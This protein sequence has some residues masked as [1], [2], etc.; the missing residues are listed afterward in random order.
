MS[1]FYQPCVFENTFR[2]HSHLLILLYAARFGTL[3]RRYAR[4]WFNRITS[5]N[6]DW[7][8]HRAARLSWVHIVL[9]DADSARV[10]D[11]WERL[12]LIP[13][14]LS[15]EEQNQSVVGYRSFLLQWYADECDKWHL[16]PSLVTDPF[17]SSENSSY[18]AALLFAST[19]ELMSD[20]RLPT[21]SR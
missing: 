13:G 18:H 21:N 14:F 16:E 10:S 5:V 7:T 3:E 9:Y 12:R 15:I 6:R 19:T 11:A 1:K 20:L 17:V 2:Y 4:Y 8:K